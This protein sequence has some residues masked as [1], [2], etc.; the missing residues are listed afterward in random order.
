MGLAE[1]FL[2]TNKT[3]DTKTLNESEEIK[4]TEKFCACGEELL[5][6]EIEAG[7]VCEECHYNKKEAEEKQGE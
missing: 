2:V 5:E 3:S 1:F 7:G 4:T 6:Y